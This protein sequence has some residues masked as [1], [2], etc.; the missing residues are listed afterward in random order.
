MKAWSGIRWDEMICNET[1]RRQIKYKL[2]GVVWHELTWNAK[3]GHGMKF[4]HELKEGKQEWINEFDEVN[5]V[6]EWVNEWVNA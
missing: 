6:D 4:N 3:E 2:D 1:R 5:E